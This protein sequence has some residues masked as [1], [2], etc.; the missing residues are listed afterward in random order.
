MKKPILQSIVSVLFLTG[1]LFSYTPLT[2]Q[3]STKAKSE[4]KAKKA[5]NAKPAAAAEQSTA[6]VL[7]LNTILPTDPQVR[8]GTLDNGIKYYIK[9]NEK[10]TGRVSMRLA[11]NAGSINETD[12]QSGLAHFTEH[13]LFNGTKNFPKNELVS[14]LQKTGMQFG[15]DVNAYT[16]FDETVYMFELPTDDKQLVG[17][18]LQVLEDW[19]HQATLEDQAIEEERGVIIEEWRSNLGAEERMRRKYMPV[20]FNKSLY[21]ERI[22]IGSGEEQ[23]KTF[24]PEELKKFYHDFYRPNLQAVIVVGDIDVNEM[25]MQI[26]A[27]FS[28][29]KNP[30]NL[31]ERKTSTIPDNAEPLVVIVTDKEATGNVIRLMWKHSAKETVTVGDYRRDLTINLV[32]EMFNARLQEL[33][34]DPKA[35]FVYAYQGYSSFIRPLDVYQLIGV[36]KENQ[37]EATLQILLTEAARVDKYGFLESELGRA[38]ESVLKRYETMA[39]EADKTNSNAYAREYTNNFLEGEAM[40]GIA[41]EYELVKQLLPTISL[42]DASKTAQDGITEN[43]CVVIVT[44]PEKEGILVPAEADIK[45]I[46][47]QSKN[48]TVEPYVDNFKAEPIVTLPIRPASGAKVAMANQL[49]FVYEITLSN[50][51]KV[52][53]KPTTLKNDQILFGA[54]A[55]GGTSTSSLENFMSA[56]LATEI[57][58][59]SGIGKFNY[60]DLSKLLQGKNVSTNVSI[61]SLRTRLNGST[62]PEDLETLLQLNYLNFTSPRKDAQAFEAYMSQMTNQ[63][64]FIA[65]SPM[66][67]FYDKLSRTSSNNDPRVFAFPSLK[68]MEEVSA[69][70]AF[71]FYKSQFANPAEFNF[72][73][74]GNFNVDNNLLSLLETYIGSL[75]VQPKSSMWKDVTVP[76]PEKTIDEKLVMGSEEQG[77]V[78]VVFEIENLNWDSEDRL[79]L[80]FFKEIISIKLFETIREKLG[81]V[82]SPRMQIQFEKYPKPTGNFMILFSCDP[83]RADELTNA[84]FDEMNKVLK[85][86]PTAEDL[87]KVQK[88]HIRNFETSSQENRFW[89]NTLQNV[90][91]EGYDLN[92]A[93]LEVQTKRAMNITASFLQQTASKYIDMN[94]YVRLVLVPENAPKK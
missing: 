84:V 46:M 8:I 53:V 21:A 7:G 69:D 33:S 23:L 19:A 64:K 50:G 22:P 40:P 60:T 58:E 90:D 72:Y 4:T 51:I 18:G 93:S 94:R 1:I 88:L 48:I 80:S 9:H 3:K 57:Q 30:E 38:K 24:K 32:A 89:L 59:M 67:S 20:L 42:A 47:A 31:V 29:I 45:N 26:K 36:A 85:D 6:T 16:S 77:M 56:Y 70:A 82:Y 66:Y 15:A 75:P 83:H 39:K 44:A 12:A 14:F 13:M 41:Y 52:I 2:A 28:S 87:D 27:H 81:G 61:E 86:G 49:Q 76:F 11:V 78:G 73:L 63:L 55:L 5:V 25:E 37:I 91:Y 71:D 62:S 17:Q 65:S 79:A 43:N 92:K 35:P 68:Q 74:V 34:Q 10:P 54:Y